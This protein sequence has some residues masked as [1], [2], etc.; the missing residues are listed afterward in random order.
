MKIGIANDHAGTKLKL[1]LV[2]YLSKK[3]YEVTDF[4]TDS[5]TASDYPVQGE[6]LANAVRDKKVELGIAI[7]GTGLGIGYACNKV[8]G[9]R[10]ACVSETTSARLSRFHNNANII[11][12]GARIVGLETAKDIVD[13]FLETPFSNEERHQRRIDMITEIEEKQ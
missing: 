11:C 4:G 9:I 3:G 5:F 1:E 10:A 8:R 7:C 6:L 12:F 13:T 2:E